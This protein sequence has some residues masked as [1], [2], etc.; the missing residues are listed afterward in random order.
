MTNEQMKE[1]ERRLD[2]TG[3]IEVYLWDELNDGDAWAS[4]DL[5]VQKL[6]QAQCVNGSWNGLIYTRDVLAKLA[7][8]HWQD[9]IDDVLAEITD[10]DQAPRI[11]SL[12]DL[13]WLAVDHTAAMMG[14]RL[15]AILETLK[16]EVAA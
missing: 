8:D 12:G 2:P 9:A 4:P 15:E 16:D 5:I 3:A 1:L 6:L 7:D 11:L 14:H 13:V 10:Y